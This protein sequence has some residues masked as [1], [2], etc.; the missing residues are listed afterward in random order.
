MIFFHAAILPLG[1]RWVAGLMVAAATFSA[2]RLLAQSFAELPVERPIS[3]EERDQWAYK[4]VANVAPPRSPVSPWNEHP[5]DCFLSSAMD[6]AGVSPL[7][8]AGKQT[9]LRR[10]S[11]DL[12]GLPPSIDQV[13]EFLH[14]DAPDAYERLVDR[15][16]ASSAYG[17][18]YAQ[19]WLDLA[20][21]AE[22]DGYEH[23]LLR[24][25]AWRYRDWVIEAINADMPYDEFVRCQIAGDLLRPGDPK[26]AIATGFLL[27]GPDMP[28]LNLQDERR[29]VVLNEITSTVGSVLLALQ[30]GCAQ[31]HDHKFDPIRQ[32]D[33]YR[34]RAFFES[35]EIFRDHP[36]P[37]A[38]ELAAREAAEAAVDPKF[39]LAGEARHTLEDA[40]RARFREQNP[41]VPPSI[42]Q[43]LAE[44]T[45]E[46]REQHAAALKELKQAPR[47]PELPLG[48]VVRE[49]KRTPAHLY[50]RGDFRQPAGELACAF[51]GVLMDGG[52]VERKESQEINPRVALAQWLTQAEHPLTSRVIVNRIWQWH[53]GA[54]LASNPSDFGVMGTE[55]AHPQLLDWLARRFVADGWS[56][57]KMHRLLVTSQ[58]YRAASAPFDRSWNEVEMARARETFERSQAADP[59]NALLW[60]RTAVRLDGEAIRDAMLAAGGRLS[61]RRGG[62][63]VR[64][65]LAAEVSGTL[66]K[67]QWIVTPDE[68][69]HRRHSVY[70]FVRR[71]LRYPLFDVFDRPD[72]N[73]SCPR[74]HESTTAT[75]SLALFNSQF[76]LESARELTGVILRSGAESG[77]G[78]IE[79]AYTRTLSRWPTTE[80]ARQGV[81]FVEQQAEQL[82]GEGRKIESLTRLSGEAPADPYRAAALVDFCLALLNANEFV[83]VD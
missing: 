41:D 45:E 8:A 36:V 32:H 20:R 77:A 67:D 28:D 61:S 57:K 3:A 42:K 29:H 15:L 40:G 44:L 21:F 14:D 65:P 27:C 26:A 64:P 43:V 55:P 25:N 62:P 80:E 47:L 1:R 38:V 63:G 49:G 51:P 73:A 16:L 54:P 10:L 5:V 60:R 78:Q 18:R 12:T 68:E 4:P 70:L 53:F 72:T 39:K 24:P 66:L 52:D 30:F 81:Q 74:R 48:R 71:N 23:D 79:A 34:L 6:A 22:T 19:H 37:T 13:R 7:P 76:S 58:A 59:H 50:L 9:L 56:L 46:E 17:E 83:Y 82:R 75:Q 31:C 69:D 33:F 11:F 2:A 35:A